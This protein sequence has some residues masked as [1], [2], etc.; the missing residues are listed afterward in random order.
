MAVCTS[1][2]TSSAATGGRGGGGEGPGGMR[3]GWGGAGPEAG[4]GDGAAEG[5]WLPI[6][7][8]RVSK[9]C[10]MRWAT[11]FR[12]SPEAWLYSMERNWKSTL[13]CSQV[14]FG[15]G[16]GSKSHVFCRCRNN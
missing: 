8:A 7:A 5:A 6:A 12:N 9:A 15:S 10:T 1:P 14:V 2:L 3:N 4:A 13:K 11:S 16:P